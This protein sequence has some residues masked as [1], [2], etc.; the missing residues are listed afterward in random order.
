MVR[1][2]W[3]KMRRAVRTRVTAF[4]SAVR[5][6]VRDAIGAGAPVVRSALA[7]GVRNVCGEQLVG[8]L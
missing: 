8:C 5:D 1:N 6:R 4:A 2:S 3:G 7:F